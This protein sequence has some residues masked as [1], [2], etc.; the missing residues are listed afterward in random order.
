MTIR[1]I[2]GLGNPGTEYEHTRHNMGVDLL[3]AIAEKY[4]IS[5]RN[6][7]KYNAEIGKGYIEEQ[8]VRLIFPTTFMNRSGDSIGPLANFFKIKPE[9]ILVIHDELDLPPGSVKIKTGGGHGG[10]NGLKSIIA[11]LGNDQGF[12]RL[13][14]GIGKPSTREEMINFVL[15]RPP[16]SEKDLI[17]QAQDEALAC[18][19]LIFSQ[20]LAKATN[21]LNGF[22]AVR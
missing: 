3:Y 15:G 13:R 10:H 9:E 7:S 16:K 1:L 17:A 4:H 22:K 8:E 18:V 19:G 14:I 11:S 20:N 5:M 12:H 21:R 2:A 6:D